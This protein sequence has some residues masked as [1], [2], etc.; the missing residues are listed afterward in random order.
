MNQTYIA[1][2]RQATPSRDFL[3]ALL[4]F[5]GVSLLYFATISGI[6]SSNDGSHYALL[7]TMV[8]NRTFALQN[9]DDYAE[10]NDIAL[11]PDG[12]LF[13]DWPPGTAVAAIP[14]YLLGDPLP[15]PLVPIPSRHNAENPRLPY[16]LLLPVFAGAGTV[17]LLYALLR[18]LR[19]GQGAALTAVL[20]RLRHRPLEVQHR[21]FLPRTL[22]LS[23]RAV[24]L[25]RA[26]PDRPLGPS[27]RI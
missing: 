12:T 24:G 19:I 17:V 20:L 15:D 21:S 8:V 11:T 22:R 1:G 7:R 6:T 4:L 10:G 13:S 25:S 23:G 14:F 9:F 26:A 18:R 5:A 16:V 3:I 2:T 27:Q